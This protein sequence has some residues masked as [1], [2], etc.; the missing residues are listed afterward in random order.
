MWDHL[1]PGAF[2][3]R[4]WS[5]ATPEPYEPTALMAISQIGLAAIAK[6]KRRPGNLIDRQRLAAI[7]QRLEQLRVSDPGRYYIGDFNELLTRRQ[8]LLDG[9]SDA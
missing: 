3:D 4:T 1:S 6:G 2:W 5:E 8:A 9:M 7:D